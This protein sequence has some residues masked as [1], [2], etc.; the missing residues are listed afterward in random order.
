MTAKAETRR[1]TCGLPQTLQM[2]SGSACAD[3][4]GDETSFSNCFPQA[5]QRYSKIGILDLG[6]ANIA[7][8][9]GLFNCR[10]PLNVAG[11]SVDPASGSAAGFP[12]HRVRGK[13]LDTH[14]T[15]A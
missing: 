13:R 10:G 5:R 7:K 6:Y 15:I 2:A 12:R 14:K 4:V 9:D 8:L 1:S 3:R 11:R